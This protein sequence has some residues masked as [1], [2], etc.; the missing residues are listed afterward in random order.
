MLPWPTPRLSA[1]PEIP[2]F[3]LASGFSGHDFGIGP[4]AGRLMADL[5]AGAPPIVDPAPF[6]FDRLAAQPRQDA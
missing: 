6:R 4:G 5:V 2:G 1:V 3:H